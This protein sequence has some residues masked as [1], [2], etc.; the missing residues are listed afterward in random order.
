MP[1][2]SEE[3]YQ[4]TLHVVQ[5]PS[6]SSFALAHKPGEDQP[7][8]RVVSDGQGIPAN[9]DP[10]RLTLNQVDEPGP[11]T[12]ADSKFEQKS[13]DLQTHLIQMPASMSSFILPHAP[14]ISK[15]MTLVLDDDDDDDYDEP[16]WQ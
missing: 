8:L 6:Q 13:H 2:G 1:S 9:L 14:A 7:S 10:F 3:H 16:P 15:P 5:M 11:G 4:H 12:L